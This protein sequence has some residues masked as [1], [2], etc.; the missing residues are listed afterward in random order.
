M[1]I[2]VFL[3]FLVLFIFYNSFG[4]ALKPEKYESEDAQEQQEYEK[5]FTYGINWNTNGGI[6]GGVD[7]KFAWQ[8]R[9]NQL[10]YNLVGIEIGHVI[11]QKERSVIGPFR[12]GSSFIDGKSNNL[13]VFRPHIGREW[14]IFRKA[15]EEGVQ[16][17]GLLAAGPTLAYLKPYYVTYAKFIRT[18]TTNGLIEYFYDINEAKFNPN[19]TRIIAGGASFFRGFD[20][21]TA[22]LGIHLKASLC[23]EYGKSGGSVGGIEVGTLFEQFTKK[24]III[25]EAENQSF[26]SSI[27][28]N[29]YFGIR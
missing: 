24:L 28:V 20:E 2:K 7:I 25:P 8:S 23:F 3:A 13:F 18:D 15:E 6:I 21:M 12:N 17:S 1:S 16:V 27:F 9:K 10:I 22:D 11:H 4:Q 5:E 19:D 14:I 26:F 29:V